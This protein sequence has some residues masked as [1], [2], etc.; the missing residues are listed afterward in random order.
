MP[1]IDYQ[2][3]RRQLHMRQVLDLIGF[4]ATGRRGPQL[5]GRC[6]IPGCRSAS[7]RSF[8]V[9]LTRQVF[10]CFACR[11]GGNALDLWAA[12]H[13]LSIHQAAV[14]LCRLTNLDLPRLT[15]SSTLSTRCQLRDVPFRAPSRNR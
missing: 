10:H 4:Q 3:L 6:P 5:R 8:S 12:V 13:S 2:Q 14:D 7:G 1:G 15:A 11:S 9:H